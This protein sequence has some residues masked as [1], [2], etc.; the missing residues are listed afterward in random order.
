MNNEPGVPDL[1]LV[2]EA[3]FDQAERT[4]ALAAGS[5]RLI[6]TGFSDCA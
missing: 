4:L 2:L 1:L 6:D 3:R 5:A